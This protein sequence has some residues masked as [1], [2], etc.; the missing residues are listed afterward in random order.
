MSRL[1]RT[2]ETYSKYVKQQSRSNLSKKGMNSSKSLYNSIKYNI[3]QNRGNSGR[4][5][6]GF[7]VGFSMDDYGEFQDKGVHGVNS[8][9]I[10]SKNSKFK[11]K[12]SSN[13]IGVEAATGTFAKFA[14]RKG[15]RFRDKKGKYITYK[16]T[17]FVIAQSIKKKGLEA[18]SFFSKP[19]QAGINKYG[20]DFAVAHLED[21]LDIIFK[22]TK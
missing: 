11:Y 4:F 5:E 12:K 19:L 7:N 17:G 21:A 10:K 3:K 2:I 6:T 9:Y 16:S 1:K 14:K 20:Q 8:S 13:L 15:L 18:T 22:E